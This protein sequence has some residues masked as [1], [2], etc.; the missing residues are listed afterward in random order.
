VPLGWIQT[1]HLVLVHTAW[2]TQPLGWLDLKLWGCHTHLLDS[3][4]HI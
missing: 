3:I 4:K 1:I 2:N